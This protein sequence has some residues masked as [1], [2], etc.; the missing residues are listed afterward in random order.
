MI[1]QLVLENFRGFEDHKL[2]LRPNTIAVGRN[3]AGKSTVIEA[4]RLVSIVSQRY[5][6]LSYRPPPDDFNLPMRL[7]G[8][9]VDISNLNIDFDS[10]CYLYSD[11]PAK[12][13]AR[14]SNECSICIY[15]SNNKRIHAVIL[16]QLGN[17]AKTRTQAAELDIP[18]IKILPQIRP[19]SKNERILNYEYVLGSM[20]SS[21]ASLHFRNQLRIFGHLWNDFKSLSETTWKGLQIRELECE[22]GYPDDP[23]RLMVRIDEF[24]GEIALMGHGLQMWLQ[25]IW[26][27]IRSKDANTIILDEPD[28]YMHA[29]LQRRLVKILRSLKKQNIIATHSVEVISEFEPEDILVIERTKRRSRFTDTIPAVQRVIEGVGSTQNIHIARLWNSKRFLIIEGHD[30]RILK[31]LHDKLYPD[32][33]ISF[34]SIPNMS[35]GGWGGWSRAIGSSMAMRNAVGESVKTYCILDR[36]YHTDEEI[37]SRLNEAKKADVLL[38]IWR[39]KEIE[40]Y[41]LLPSVIARIIK[42]RVT[43]ADLDKDVVLSLLIEFAEDMR[44]ETF[45]SISDE[46]CRNNR[47]INSSTANKIARKLIEKRTSSAF[48]IIDI[49]SGKSLLSNVSTWLQKDYGISLSAAT[50]ANE[51]LPEEIPREMI[52]IISAIEKMKSFSDI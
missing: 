9:S 11:P 42:S 37:N 25:F 4:M 30:L 47:K 10:I 39:K 8:A 46:I 35:I 32:S 13:E 26:F 31:R 12:I 24:V 7:Y 38:H 29:D 2:E 41:L 16:G 20:D 22:R 15:I 3:N 45:D 51:I 19:L 18:I 48:G 21:L 17:P 5:K 23:M 43:K 27:L 50:L 52:R 40:N 36:D 28:V 34:E 1:V 44:D 6:S 14:F 33:D 49:V